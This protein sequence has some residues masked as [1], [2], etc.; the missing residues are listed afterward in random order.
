MF[1]LNENESNDYATVK[2]R[3]NAHFEVRRNVVFE[4]VRFNS[5]N[6]YEGSSLSTSPLDYEEHVSSE[7]PKQSNAQPFSVTPPRR[8]SQSQPPKVKETL[9]KMLKHVIQKT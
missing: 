2:D 4:R 8:I 9:D 3:F 1:G 6:Q 7:F 5:R